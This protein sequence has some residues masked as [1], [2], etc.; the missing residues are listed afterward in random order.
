MRS[1][2]TV[3]LTSMDS[4]FITQ[5]TWNGSSYNAPVY[6]NVGG[7]SWGIDLLSNDKAIVTLP[8]EDHMV[9]LDWNAGAGKFAVTT[10]WYAPYYSTDIIKSN[11]PRRVLV[12]NRGAAPDPTAT[13][14]QS[15]Q[16]AVYDLDVFFG[17][18]IKR[19]LVCDREPRVLAL[20]PDKKR[21][22]V[23]HVQGALGQDS[24]DPGTMGPVGGGDHSFSND[25]Y[26]GGSI[27][28]FNV[29]G[30]THD[31]PL[32]RFLIGSP[33]R[34]LAIMPIDGGMYRLFFTHVGFGAAAEDP[35]FG[36]RDIANIISSIAFTNGSHVP[37]GGREDFV[38][39]HDPDGEASGND[40]PAILPERIAVR[41]AGGRNELWIA[42]SGS[43]SVSRVRLDADGLVDAAGQIHIEFPGIKPGVPRAPG[44]QLDGDNITNFNEFHQWDIDEVVCDS[45]AHYAVGTI[46]SNPRSLVVANDRVYVAANLEHQLAVINA[47][48]EVTDPCITFPA[49]TLSPLIS[50]ANPVEPDEKEFFAFGAAFDFRE[51]GG[52]A[53]E[54]LV[55]VDGG[56]F[57]VAQEAKTNTITCGTCHV[58][59]HLDGKVRFIVRPFRTTGGANFARGNLV[60]TGLPGLIPTKKAKPVQVP[61]IFDVGNTEWIFFEGT[62]T[63][64]DGKSGSSANP[65]GSCEYCFDN[66]FFFN[67]PEF[68]NTV[69]SP[70]SPHA[71]D[72]TLSRASQQKGRLLFE[73][74][75]CSRCHAGATRQTF[76]RTKNPSG[77]LPFVG[78]FGPLPGGPP[79]SGGLVTE[80]RFLNDPTQIF[81]DGD[82]NSPDAGPFATRNVTNVGTRLSGDGV[83]NGTHTPALAGL[84]DNRPYMHD[85][86]YRTIEEVLTNTWLD[87]TDAYR[88]A[89]LVLEGV[90]DNSKNG[91][92]EDDPSE[93]TFTTNATVFPFGTHR[94]FGGSGTLVRAIDY[95]DGLG[96][97]DDF[98]DFLSS[99]S[100]QTS[101]CD[102]GAAAFFLSYDPQPST[103]VSTVA[104]DTPVPAE[105]RVEWRYLGGGTLNELEI[106]P[107][108]VAHTVLVPTEAA[109]AYEIVLT[110]YMR[111]V[112]FDPLQM[113]D[114]LFV[115]DACTQFANNGPVFACPQGD[116][117]ALVV[118]VQVD[119][120]DYAGA[121]TLEASRFTIGDPV[122]GSVII[123]PGPGGPI[124]ADSNAVLVDTMLTTTFTLAYLSGCAVE[125]DATVIPV[126]V[127]SIPVGSSVAVIRSADLTNDAVVDGLDLTVLGNTYAKCQSDPGYNDCA[128]FASADTCV[129]L[130]DLVA[131]APHY[132]DALPG[133]SA[134]AT[135]KVP[136]TRMRVDIRMA[137]PAAN[138]EAI[139]TA[140]VQ[141]ARLDGVASFAMLLA[142]QVD[143]LGA[144][145]WTPNRDVAPRSFLVPFDTPA[146]RQWALF[147]SD[148]DAA[149][150]SIVELG[151]LA[152]KGDDSAGLGS[153]LTLVE[154]KVVTRAGTAQQMEELGFSD[155]P[156]TAPV[157][158]NYLGRAYPNP[159][160]PS[161]T[162]RYAI[163]ATAEVNLSVYD[164]HG[165]LVKTLVDEHQKQSEYTTVWNGTDARGN[166][167]A[168]GVYFYRLKTPVFVET[169]KMV[170]LK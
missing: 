38:L 115:G 22:F 162:I 119:P 84:W 81:I 61:T 124:H 2:G 12:A 104:F 165:R 35:D 120:D 142:P 118:T 15:W 30:G 133:S 9:E 6:I 74:M 122:G 16:H 23:G 27:I 148:L 92:F 68:T 114:T 43:G 106:T 127:D 33:V 140:T 87:T 50:G 152:F 53:G 85:G 10:Q 42:N 101:L 146:G 143:G 40:R 83:V 157:A 125:P 105:V 94:Q 107:L 129:D 154:G 99:V 97:R 1:D 73:A 66:G 49:A 59:G 158:R 46:F 138:G 149:G 71:T 80:N 54:R 55:V 52:P 169:R 151:T 48:A 111:T 56:Q 39:G 136:I 155:T 134:P 137:P 77:E 95:L 170:L 5:M 67:T 36:G 139:R 88:A 29:E 63:V 147:A 89:P 113:V 65:L 96:A 45:V 14:A 7:R 166:P 126:L 37:T 159:F 132:N 47:T 131:F 69:A 100:S 150:A 21:L 161:T 4:N 93:L 135:A 91:E 31:E 11:W 108:G 34:G 44:G 98:I 17:T 58:D 112:C 25:D 76:P 90:P 144:I 26:D 57:E 160:N 75:N 32:H 110:A 78:Q 3:L 62:R 102:L 145:E 168:S 156:P 18:G 86:R 163:K 28:V 19:T 121:D 64:R 24:Y 20:S 72:G 130:V 82:P 13:G 51:N 164:V 109:G 70:V 123:H 116:A 79:T 117:E 167:V 128:N 141:A 41:Q 103:C 153:P 8:F 60:K